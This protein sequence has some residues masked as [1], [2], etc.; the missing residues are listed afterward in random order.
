[1][2][3]KDWLRITEA[4]A[5]EDLERTGRDIHSILERMVGLFSKEME[6][7]TDPDAVSA[8]CNQLGN[9]LM[10][11]SE[12]ASDEAKMF[13]QNLA[14]IC[15]VEPLKGENTL[16]LPLNLYLKE[17]GKPVIRVLEETGA[18]ATHHMKQVYAKNDELIGNRDA[19]DCRTECVQ[20]F[21]EMPGHE[22]VQFM[23]N[24][25][26]E[27]EM[28]D[29]KKAEIQKLMALI[30]SKAK[31]LNGV[32]MDFNDD[33]CKE[34]LDMSLTLLKPLT[35][36]IAAEITIVAGVFQHD[37]TTIQV[38]GREWTSLTSFKVNFLFQVVR[39][40]TEGTLRTLLTNIVT[41]MAILTDINGIMLSC[42]AFHGYAPCTQISLNFFIC[43][44]LSARL[45]L[46]EAFDFEFTASLSRIILS[47]TQLSNS[48]KLNMTSILCRNQF[49]PK[50]G[51]CNSVH[52]GSYGQDEHPWQVVQ[53]MA[54]IFP[55]RVW[56]FGGRW[57]RD[58]FEVAG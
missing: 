3:D 6:A 36:Q 1:M 39:T 34:L 40:F 13:M 8:I 56:I 18:F 4:L 33:A 22:V 32:C 15:L 25:W 52:D 28:T 53:G 54:G 50:R 58:C 41:K 17:T 14:A 31:K 45:V 37:T 57:T 51:C 47:K 55:F 7:A 12:K 9:S 24:P 10:L 29:E 5:P 48:K 49:V 44:N 38:E 2:E 11:V 46:R 26:E 23:L 30:I 16:E 20:F 43:A 21:K 27:E 35:D 42:D 19:A